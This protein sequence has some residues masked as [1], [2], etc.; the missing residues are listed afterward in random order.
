MPNFSKQLLLEP[1]EPLEP[2]PQIALPPLV[3]TILTTLESSGFQ[4]FVI[5]GCVRD[6]LLGKSPKDWDIATDATPEQILALFSPKHKLITLGARF[7]TIGVLESS[8]QSTPNTAQNAGHIVEITTFRLESGYAD[9]RRPDAVRYAHSLLDDIAR[10]DFTCNALA[11]NPRLA[12]LKSNPESNALDSGV[13]DSALA[14]SLTQAYARYV[15]Y[16]HNGICDSVGGLADLRAGS[17]RCVGEAHRRF[18]EDGL[19]ILRGLRFCASFGFS[20]ESATQSALRSCAPTLAAISS[21]RKQDEWDKILRSPHI[22][23]AIVP[24]CAVYAEVFSEFAPELRAIA[25]SS[26]AQERLRTSLQAIERYNTH[27]IT[28]AQSEDHHSTAQIVRLCAWF[29][30]VAESALDSRALWVDSSYTNIPSV[31]DIGARVERCLCDLRYSRHI[32]T[33]CAR[34]MPYVSSFGA[35]LQL[36]KSHANLTLREVLALA[37]ELDKD[38]ESRALRHLTLLAQILAVL[39]GSQQTRALE[40]YIAQ[41]REQRYCYQVAMLAINGDE[42][43]GIAP[44]IS[45]KEIGM[46]LRALLARVMNCVL[47]NEPNA[48]RAAAHDI[49]ES[50]LQ[51]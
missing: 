14:P 39:H 43:G 24:F 12:K 16:L 21:E 37:H 40:Q 2:L 34:L 47:P 32:T 36:P 10:R 4:G 44:M 9:S 49:A 20:L 41:I 29:C 5:G 48:L 6:S 42:I 28:R 1:L 17:L 11:Y 7:G 27:P 33:T 15:P 46:I 45:G 30:A 19:R 50:M 35:R 26:S 23:N 51:S 18:S 13:V 8:S 22:A 31:S 38:T 25:E 3:Q